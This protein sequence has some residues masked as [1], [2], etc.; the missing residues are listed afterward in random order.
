MSQIKRPINLW[1]GLF[2][3]SQR[4]ADSAPLLC[5]IRELS[6]GATASGR[7]RVSAKV[8]EEPRI[9][10]VGER[11][12]NHHGFE[13]YGGN[14]SLADDQQALCVGKPRERIKSTI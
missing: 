9:Q 13:P 12:H 4:S 11:R 3:A 14:V 8:H 1:I 10:V 6:N 7:P 5:T 2:F